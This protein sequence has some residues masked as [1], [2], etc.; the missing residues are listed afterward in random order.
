MSKP[1]PTERRPFPFC[2]F[3]VRNGL[4]FLLKRYIIIVLHLF[5]AL[6]QTLGYPLDTLIEGSDGFGRNV[7]GMR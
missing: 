5:T 3:D 4:T 2:M 6:L 1:V 7:S